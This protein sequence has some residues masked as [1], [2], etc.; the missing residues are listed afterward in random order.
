MSRRFSG[1]G[2]NRR[3]VR[4]SETGYDPGIE[5][6]LRVDLWAE[7]GITEAGTGVSS[8]VDRKGSVA[9]TQAADGAR[10][11]YEQAGLGGRPSVLFVQANSDLLVTASG[12]IVSAT[13]SYSCI[14]A[15]DPITNSAD[16]DFLFDSE[17][18]RLIFCL[19]ISGAQQ[20][21]FHDGGFDG[22]A[23]STL[24]PQ[25]LRWVATDGGNQEVFRGNT[26]LGTAPY[27]PTNLG[28]RASLGGNYVGTGGFADVRIGRMMIFDTLDSARDARVLSWMSSHYGISL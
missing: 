19:N 21:G 18:G 4:S 15:L 22:I 2:G 12:A 14:A 6:G 25:I 11:T 24:P 13:R 7:A 17:T 23:A 20:V 26:S 28:G 10:P 5:S 1:V 8:W 27:T 16:G 3:D 9:F